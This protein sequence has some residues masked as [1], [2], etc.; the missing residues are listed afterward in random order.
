MLVVKHKTRDDTFLLRELS[1]QINLQ[2]EASG[3]RTEGS[4]CALELMM[5]YYKERQ[6]Q[7][8][9]HFFHLVSRWVETSP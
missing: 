7:S 5:S 9:F 3:L 4:L 8:Q 2:T 1:V 6:N